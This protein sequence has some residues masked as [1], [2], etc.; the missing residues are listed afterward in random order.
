MKAKLHLASVIGISRISEELDI[1]E[2]T[3]ALQKNSRIIKL[4]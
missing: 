1:V 3:S 4:N 2:S